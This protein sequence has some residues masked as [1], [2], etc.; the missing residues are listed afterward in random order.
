[1]MSSLERVQ[2]RMMLGTQLE[3]IAWFLDC[4]DHN[5][6]P[7]KEQNWRQ[8]QSTLSKVVLCFH[9]MEEDMTRTKN[10]LSKHRLRV[11]EDAERIGR[12][13]HELESTQAE[14]E[15]LK[16]SLHDA[17]ELL[18]ENNLNTLQLWRT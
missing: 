10:D 3:A 13:K 12:M 9:D 6:T 8:L 14:N 4:Q 5:L 18:T 2:A 7:E 15:R 11:L 1:M 16:E 17:I